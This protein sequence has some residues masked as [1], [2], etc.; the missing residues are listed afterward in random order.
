MEPGDIQ[1]VW[2]RLINS[3]RSK[4]ETSGEM[5]TVE[6]STAIAAG[7]IRL[8]ISDGRYCT[9]LLPLALADAIEAEQVSQLIS[10]SP[11][12]LG[13][14]GKAVRFL[15]VRCEEEK[16]N[17]VFARVVSDILRRIEAGSGA[18][19]SVNEALKEFRRLLHR[20]HVSA[21]DEKTIVGLIGELLTLIE[22]LKID[23][24]GLRGW[25]GP[26]ADRHD[27][28]AGPVTIE[29]KTSLGAD[30]SKIHINGMRQLE[31]SADT[32]LL[33][34]HIRIE[35]DPDGNLSVPDLVSATANLIPDQI[36]LDEKL[37]KLGYTSD[38]AESWASKRFRHIE[39]SA[40]SVIEGFP[41]LIPALL[42]VP[43]PVGGVSAVSYEVNLGAASQFRVDESIWQEKL[44]EFCKCL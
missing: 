40:Y 4:E 24:G 1:A 19:K 16:L 36:E 13:L 32:E 6:T 25:H 33:I 10:V 2:Q 11:V 15:E 38:N 17:E 37:E 21:Q 41:R 34:R 43:W 20:E 3:E 42:N 5:P 31:P 18:L 30:G 7:L 23:Q 8:A 14:D 27:F 39:S 28:R 22:V 12:T 26:D 29:I 35:P 44:R 9:V